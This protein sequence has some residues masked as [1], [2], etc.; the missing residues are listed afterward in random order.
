MAIQEQ[1]ISWK[2][3]VKNTVLIDL[4]VNPEYNYTDFIS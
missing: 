3:K 1:I 2:L 4:G